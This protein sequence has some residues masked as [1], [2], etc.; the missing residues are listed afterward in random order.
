MTSNNMPDMTGVML[1]GGRYAP[2]TDAIGFLEA[3]FAQVVEAD[4][5]WRASLGGY[6][7]RPVSGTL[8]TLLDSLLPLTAPLS[9]HVWVETT[10]SWTAYFDNFV[11]GSDTFGPVSYLARQLGCRGF[12]I[13]CREGTPARDAARS[14]AM[15][16]AEQTDWLNVVRS[17]AA[18]QED[19]RWTWSAQ[20]APQPFEDVTTYQRRLV[21]DRLTPGMLAAYC[22]A[23]GIRPFDES[24]YGA[25]GQIT[26]NIRAMQ[27]V[28]TETLQQARARHGL[29]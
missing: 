9:R 4:S 26:Q 24:F 14:F 3:D 16:G 20:G 2:I 12:A 18:V 13:G 5:R 8:P 6:R 27:N 10:G 19:G 15:Y 1:P 25:A 7:S 29:E 28:R 23:L 21:R 22:G 17:V 11:D